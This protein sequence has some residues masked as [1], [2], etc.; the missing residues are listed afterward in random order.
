[1]D[2]APEP[3]SWTRDGNTLRRTVNAPDFPAAISIVTA[4]ADEAERMNHHPD[5]D[6]R[7]RTVFFA[8]TTHSTGGLTDL[9]YELAGHIDRIVAEHGG[10]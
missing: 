4:V 10:S 6:I 9:D 2:N 8:L 3:A 7:W 5:I 1:M